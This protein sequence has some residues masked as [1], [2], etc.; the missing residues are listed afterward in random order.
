MFP[1]EKS[2][3][4]YLTCIKISEDIIF[5]FNFSFKEIHFFGDKTEQGGNDYEIFEDP[6]TI[7][8]KVRNPKDTREQLEKLFNL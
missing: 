8:H 4:L 6:R 2:E 5:S 7:G 3:F 1:K